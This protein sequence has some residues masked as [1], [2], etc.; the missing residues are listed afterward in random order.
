MQIWNFLVAILGAWAVT[1][2]GR[3]P[4]WL[5]SF[6]G[7]TLADVLLIITTSSTISSANI[8]QFQGCRDTN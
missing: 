2:I 1:R 8:S 7:M 6:V 3:R 4:L 5:V